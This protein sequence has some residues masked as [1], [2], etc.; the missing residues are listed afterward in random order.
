MSQVIHQIIRQRMASV[1]PCLLLAAP[2]LSACS[3]VEP[4]QKGT[5]AKPAMQFDTEPLRSRAQQHIYASKEAASGG[6]GVGGGGC[7][8]N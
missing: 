4:W 6:A 8:C 3:H 2:L 5:L 7:G 1:L